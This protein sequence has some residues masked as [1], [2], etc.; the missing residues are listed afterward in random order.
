MEDEPE[1]YFQNTIYLSSSENIDSRKLDKSFLLAS[2][3]EDNMFKITA[4]DDEETFLIQFRMPDW[5]QRK[6]KEF[7]KRI[8]NFKLLT[9]T[10][11]E[12]F[13]KKRLILYKPDSFSL[14]LTIFYTIIFDEEKISF[15]LHK[16]CEDE[17]DEKILIGKFFSASEPIPEES[18]I[19]YRAELI[20]YSKEFEDYGDRSI[21]R[22]RVENK[23]N[24][25]WER[26]RT[27]FQCVP[28]FSTLLCNEYYLEEDVIPGDQVEIPLEFMKG[29]PDNME[30]PYFTFLHL[31][32]HP[33]NFEPMLILDFDKTFKEEKIKASLIKDKNQEIKKDNNIKK[34]IIKKEEKKDEIKENKSDDENN[35]YEIKDDKEEEE[36][37]INE[38]SINEKKEENNEDIK[39][40]LNDGKKNKIIFD[41]VKVNI[42]FNVE[43]NNKVICVDVNENKVNFNIDKNIVKFVDNKK[44]KIHVEEKKPIKK[45]N[46]NKENKENKNQIKNENNDINKIE[47]ASFKDKIKFFSQTKK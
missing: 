28:E 44:N 15:E 22:L 34:N 17:E 37:I 43:N 3:I 27:S 14:M 20:E 5:A 25:T 4:Q 46:D 38:N 29:D 21:I 2:Y 45:I 47:R 33:R 7:T 12:A 41:N 36:N 39:I 23:G 18:N 13:E 8:N 19:D 31:H 32:I 9:K 10:I 16:Q 40:D 6:E 26:R 35:I 30:P 24:C 42:T 11:K 1:D